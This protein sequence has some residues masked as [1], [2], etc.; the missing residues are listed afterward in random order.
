M[1]TPCDA[2]AAASVWA[3]TAQTAGLALTS[4]ASGVGALYAALASRHSRS[5]AAVLAEV[6]TQTN[7]ML[8]RLA[9]QHAD[10]VAALKK[11]NG[12]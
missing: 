6:R 5:N 10:A 4:L 12:E 9:E 11:A 2:A 8:H 7:G 3:S 1:P